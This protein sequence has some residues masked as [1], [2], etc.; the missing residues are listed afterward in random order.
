MFIKD[1]CPSADVASQTNYNFQQPTP[2]TVIHSHGALNE[3]TE[4]VAEDISKDYIAWVNALSRT[5]E[6]VRA[7]ALK[8]KVR[9]AFV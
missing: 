3:E 1:D 4:E 2:Q 9:W 7:P 6:S 8:Q 5:L